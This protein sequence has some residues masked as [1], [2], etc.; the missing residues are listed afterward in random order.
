MTL[1]SSL[2]LVANSKN[3]IRVPSYSWA[4]ADSTKAT[5][6][7]AGAKAKIEALDTGIISV[8]VID[9]SNGLETTVD[10]E[11]Y[12]LEKSLSNTA[13]TLSLS[14]EPETADA[15]T[16]VSLKAEGLDADG[17]LLLY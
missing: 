13:P 12:G 5:L 1:D 17:D 11:I 3:A 7:S 14:L 2:Y 10:I 8:L 4:L 16:D 15:F 9:H 6:T